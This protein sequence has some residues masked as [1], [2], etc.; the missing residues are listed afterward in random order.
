LTSSPY[1][2]LL[3]PPALDRLL[4]SPSALRL[5]RAIVNGPEVPAASCLPATICCHGNKTHRRYATNRSNPVKGTWRRWQEPTKKDSQREAIRQFLE[6]GADRNEDTDRLGAMRNG[7]KVGDAAKDTAKWVGVLSQRERQEGE[8]GIMAV[9]K[10]RQRAHFDLPC[11]SSDHAEYLWGTFL[12][13]PDLVQEVVMHAAELR[14]KTKQTPSRL[15][16]LV[17]NHW[18]PRDATK[19]LEFHH[20]MVSKLHIEHLRLKG[21]AR[22]GQSI[23]KPAAYE[24]LME[25]YQGSDDRDLYDE[26]VPVLIG[27]GHINLARR[28]HIL[29]MSRKDRASDSVAQHPVIRIFRAE[30]L[31]AVKNK[32]QAQNN[33]ED[34]KD[35]ARKR[36]IYN[37]ELMQ[38]LLGRDT[39]PVRFEDSFCARLF[40]TGT[41]PPASV[42]NGL[43]L[44]GVNEIGP[45]AVLAMASRTEPIEDLPTR[46]EELRA[47]GIALQGSVFSLAVEKFAKEHKWKLVR[48]MLDSDQHPDVFGDA[49]VQRKLLDFYLDQ[50]DH[51]QAQRTLAILTLFHNHSSQESWNL[52]LQLHIRRT[53]AQHVTEVLQDMRVRGVMVSA[54]SIAAIKSLIRHRRV[55]RRPTSSQHRFDDLR[56]VT[57]VL[58]SISEFGMGP[59]PPRTWH[60][61][62]RRFGMT[63]RFRELRRLL[64]WLLCW[65]APRGSCQFTTLPTS[66]FRVRALEKFR[67]AHAGGKHWFFFPNNVTQRQNSLHPVRQLIPPSLQQ[68]LII[69]GFRAGL[70]P[71]ANLEQSL[72]GSTLS[73]KHYRHRLLQAQI[74]KRANWSI[75]LRTV[76]L[77][78]DL[79]VRVHYHTV[80]KALQMQFT[81]LFGRGRSNKLENRIMEKVNTIPYTQYV[82]EVNEIWGSNLFREPRLFHRGMVQ[83]RMWHPRMRRIIDRRA[84]IRI[85]DILGKDWQKR[86][87]HVGNVVSGQD[88]AALKELERRFK[89]QALAPE[90]GVEWMSEASLDTTGAS[91][92]DRVR[93]VRASAG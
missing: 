54:D 8:R 56:F 52:L 4:A 42:I 93:R 16:P 48:S 91:E 59:I 60:E 28:W 29:C 53:G 71:N 34:S 2:T 68:G 63:G 1:F 88:D 49:E 69:W 74:L 80:V 36:G 90:P 5:L 47:H 43:S 70:L 9:W 14:K 21:I 11:D 57:R 13:H 51:V 25:I 81:V 73:K 10:E 40:A 72:L 66:P 85:S 76:V 24:A 27:K 31:E 55:G 84:F 77:L 86:T 30:A 35:V 58:M 92:G 45:Q 79:G 22:K 23:F 44:V 65:Y 6:D 75:G 67:T 20:L 61:L 62:I 78:R 33:A 46:F 38:R 87:Q 3:M 64:L 50:E 41:F 32:P 17:M 37:E 15:Y 18:L 83:D 82:H 89:A 39:A 26:V 7:T 12:K 19:A